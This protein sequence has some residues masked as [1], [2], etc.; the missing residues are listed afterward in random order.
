MYTYFLMEK[1][2]ENKILEIRNYIK[3]II[4]FIL[5]NMKHKSLLSI[6]NM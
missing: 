3:D 1:F 6:R 2:S 5:K 4:F